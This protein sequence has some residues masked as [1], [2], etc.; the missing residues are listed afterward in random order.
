MQQR[1]W[2]TGAQLFDGE[3]LSDGLGVC[4]EKEEIAAVLPI[5]QIPQAA[6]R[7]TLDG[8]I[9][10]PG[11]IDVQVNGGGGTMVI[12]AASVSDLQN[13]VA[14]HRKFGTTSMMPTIMSDSKHKMARAVHLISQAAATERSVLGVHIEGPFFCA[15][16]KGAHKDDFIRKPDDSDLAWLTSGLH[17]GSTIKTIVTLSPDV[18]E[19]DYIRRLVDFGI[20]VC[21]GHSDATYSTTLLALQA[22]VSGFTHLHNAMR[23]ML[24]REPG[25]VGAALESKDAWVSV[26]VDKHHLHKTTLLNSMKVKPLQKI[27]LVTDAM[28]TVG[29]DT[30]SFTLY[31]EQIHLQQDKLV[32]NHGRLAGSAISM[33][34][35]VKN[36]TQWL[37]LPLAEALRMASLYP[38]EFLG[39][40]RLGRIKPGFQANLV[41]FDSQYHVRATWV[42]GALE[43]YR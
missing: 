6:T 32:N 24:A 29:S 14:A 10:A 3:K 36:T 15:S 18:V 34:D 41:H 33:M 39:E 31:D 4:I 11:F 8:G 19:L 37:G 20:I 23:P 27:I 21:C 38:A 28:A 1:Q 5:E 42:G 7:L 9:L 43:Q 13:V 22:G 40:P 12:D 30:T 35:A 16:R 25:V 2:I 17:S 26:I